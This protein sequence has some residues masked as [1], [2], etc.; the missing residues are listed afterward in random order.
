MAKTRVKLKTDESQSIIGPRQLKSVFS[1]CLGFLVVAD[2]KDLESV[3]SPLRINWC[4]AESQPP[5]DV[6]QELSLLSACIKC[7][8]KNT[9]LNL[10]SVGFSVLELMTVITQQEESVLAFMVLQSKNL[11]KGF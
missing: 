9:R 1:L 6:G 8:R 11:V 7:H 2:R 4:K 5:R 10:A 3:L